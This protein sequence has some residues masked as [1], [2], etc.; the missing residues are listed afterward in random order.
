MLPTITPHFDL[1]ALFPDT[2]GRGEFIVSFP[3]YLEELKAKGFVQVD[4]IPFLDIGEAHVRAG[5][6]VTLK[7]ELTDLSKEVEYPKSAIFFGLLFPS[8]DADNP[9]ALFADSKDM[10]SISRASIADRETAMKIKGVTDNVNKE[11]MRRGLPE[12]P[13]IQFEQ[14]SL[15][16][17]I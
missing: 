12:C 15:S 8:E 16:E 4:K 1:K 6:V 11:L 3:E 2:D 13:M 14:T 9:I 10:I 5:K 7:R 17:D